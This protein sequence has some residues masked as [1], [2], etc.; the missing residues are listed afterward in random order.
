MQE[1]PKLGALLFEST[2]GAFF[3]EIDCVPEGVHGARSF[4]SRNVTRHRKV[5]QNLPDL[6]I[7]LRVSEQNAQP[8]AHESGPHAVH[9]GLAVSLK[10]GISGLGC[11]RR[12][13]HID[14]PI[15][16]LL[17]AENDLVCPRLS[18]AEEP[19]RGCVSR[20]L[21]VS[22]AVFNSSSAIDRS[23]VQRYWRS[24]ADARGSVATVL[25][26]RFCPG[27]T[28]QRF[29]PPPVLVTDHARTDMTAARKAFVAL[30][31][32]WALR[33]R[34]SPRGVGVAVAMHWSRRYTRHRPFRS[35]R[36]STWAW[37]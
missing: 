28:A 6:R 26:Q 37:A 16:R 15:V 32:L 18:I 22:A 2:E 24:A 35:C 4:A 9:V 30:E 1:V 12:R 23:S 34:R 33:G 11:G 17:H 5:E 21:A 14:Q 20:C 8:V 29:C 13:R 31:R 36:T 10:Q 7:T 19:D 25:A 27:L 3:G